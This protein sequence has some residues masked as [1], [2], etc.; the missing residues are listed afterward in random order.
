MI[1]IN[2]HS[3]NHIF[4]AD[5]NIYFRGRMCFNGTVCASGLVF[6]LGGKLRPGHQENCQ[7]EGRKRAL[8]WKPKGK[9]TDLRS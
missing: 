4:L 8:A 6:I 9:G 2:Y 5:R 1:M 7:K 3:D